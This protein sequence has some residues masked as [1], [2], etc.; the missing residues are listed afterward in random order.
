MT[1]TNQGRIE[2]PFFRWVGPYKNGSFHP[3]TLCAYSCGVYQHCREKHLQR[4]L[5]ELDFCYNNRE[6]TDAERRNV[7]LKGIEGRHLSYRGT[8]TGAHV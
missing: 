3:E 5:D 6:I 4:Y 2:G 7:I 8:A 1:M